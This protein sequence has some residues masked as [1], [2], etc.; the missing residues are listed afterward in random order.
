MEIDKLRRE[1]REKLCDHKDKTLATL[2]DPYLLG[3]YRQRLVHFYS[4]SAFSSAINDTNINNTMV[5]VLNGLVTYLDKFT[6]S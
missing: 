1:P 5:F 3:V 4:T 6:S 2:S